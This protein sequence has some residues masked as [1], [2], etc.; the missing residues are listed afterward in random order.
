MKGKKGLNEEIPQDNM[1]NWE[2]GWCIAV[3][4]KYHQTDR[5]SQC[6]NHRDQIH[7]PKSQ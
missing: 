1:R 2:N 6:S 5:R 3:I 4:A 7:N